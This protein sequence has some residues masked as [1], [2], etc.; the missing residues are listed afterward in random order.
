L[1]SNH[2]SFLG[3]AALMFVAG[4]GI[5]LMA[6]L[7][8]ELGR[9]L[10]SPAAATFVLYVVGLALALGVLLA[11]GGLPAA[12]QF[13]G[14]RPHFYMGAVFVVFYIFAITW[15]GP[16]IGIGN[17]V[18][19]VLLGQLAAAAAIDHYGLWG[20][21]QTAITPKRVAGIAVMALGVYLARKPV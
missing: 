21:V 1:Q 20:A 11:A 10:A 5:P 12:E 18:F 19:F 13:K 6:T 4:I 8:A 3:I 17:A 2:A 15:A 7:N 9:Q 16:K 14:I